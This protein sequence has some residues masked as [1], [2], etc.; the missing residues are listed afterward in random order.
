MRS[1]LECTVD[2]EGGGGTEDERGIVL[3]GEGVEVVGATQEGEGAALC[4]DKVMVATR[5]KGGGG[6][7]DS[8]VLCPRCEGGKDG[9]NGDGELDWGG[10]STQQLSRFMGFQLVKRG[11]AVDCCTC[12]KGDGV[13]KEVAVDYSLVADREFLVGAEV[14]TGDLNGVTEGDFFTGKKDEGVGGGKERWASV[15]TEKD[16]SGGTQEKDGG[17]DAGGSKERKKF[18]IHSV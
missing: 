11:V 8:H 12:L 14:A 6:A 3:K 18:L 15:E 16:E 4:Y 17:D 5:R 9:D 7:G 13:G 1:S 2:I 10:G